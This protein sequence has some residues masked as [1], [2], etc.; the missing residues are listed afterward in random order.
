MG[1]GMTVGQVGDNAMMG[2]G[3][4]EGSSFLAFAKILVNTSKIQLLP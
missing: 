3:R 2:R 4:N 1:R